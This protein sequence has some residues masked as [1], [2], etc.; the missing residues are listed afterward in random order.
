MTRTSVPSRRS[1][2]GWSELRGDLEVADG[3]SGG[4]ASRGEESPGWAGCILSASSG[5][6]VQASE[7]ASSK[8]TLASFGC[9]G[10]DHT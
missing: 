9:S 3:E 2:S 8:T 7:W 10:M 1:V 5:R 4:G 6:M